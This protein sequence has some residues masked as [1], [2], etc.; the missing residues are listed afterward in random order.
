[1][2]CDLGSI[3]LNFFENRQPFHLKN[4]SWDFLLSSSAGFGKGF[5]EPKPPSLVLPEETVPQ[6]S[7][8][9]PNRSRTVLAILGYFTR[10]LKSY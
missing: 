6:E 10:V 3:V 8:A 1:M 4:F 7:A 5:F 2:Y 9:F